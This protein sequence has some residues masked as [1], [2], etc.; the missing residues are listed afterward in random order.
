MWYIASIRSSHK[1]WCS[2]G[3]ALDDVRGGIGEC[4]RI[5]VD[6]Q[7]FLDITEFASVE[8]QYV[9]IDKDLN[10]SDETVSPVTGMFECKLFFS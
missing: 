1:L 4:S 7:G 3:K 8:S 5:I 6:K 9:F 2:D 10:F